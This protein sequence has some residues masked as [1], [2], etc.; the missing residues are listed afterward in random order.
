MPLDKERDRQLVV[1]C[2]RAKLRDDQPSYDAFFGDLFKG[3]YAGVMAIARRATRKPEDAE[4]V[5][6]EAFKD[7]DRYITRVDPDQGSFGLLRVFVFRQAAEKYAALA[8]CLEKEESFDPDKHPEPVSGSPTYE[9]W[10]IEKARARIPLARAEFLAKIVCSRGAGAPNERMIFLFCRT[11]AYKPAR[12]ADARFSERK[13]GVDFELNGVPLAA[14]ESELE[15]EWTERSELQPDRIQGMF[16]PLRGDMNVVLRAYPLHGRTRE[17][18]SDKHI[19]E[20]PIRQ[21]RL[22]EYFRTSPPTEDI[23]MWCVN[24]E[25]RVVKLARNPGTARTDRQ[26]A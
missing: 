16:E 17:L 23:R 6:S 5:A 19:W 14:I 2:Q 10:L 25:K 26:E 4:E 18:Y 11:L 3:H 13:L 8:D 20:L 9:S 21:G 12:L 15:H 7:L 24:V 1:E 22:R